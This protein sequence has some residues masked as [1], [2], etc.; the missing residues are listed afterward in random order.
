MI[1]ALLIGDW[2]RTVITSSHTTAF[3]C[4]A[5]CGRGHYPKAPAHPLLVFL[6]S[7]TLSP[8]SYAQ[9]EGNIKTSMQFNQVHP[10][11]K[12]IQISVFLSKFKEAISTIVIL[13]NTES[14]CNEQ[15]PFSWSLY[16]THCPHSLQPLG[17]Q[18]A[19]FLA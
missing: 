16:M 18:P 2:H 1:T 7:G 13:D 10:N 5:V 17:A 8:A 15:L 14:G 12:H 19:L 4:H 11:P 3:R 9:T 6:G